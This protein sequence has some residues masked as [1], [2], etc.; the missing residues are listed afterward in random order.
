M[1]F[2]FLIVFLVFVFWKIKDSS[3]ESFYLTG[4]DSFIEVRARACD[5][6][7]V[8]PQI[9]GL[10]EELDRKWNRFSPESEIFLLNNSQQRVKLSPDTIV[11]LQKALF[12]KQKTGG[13]FNP[14]VASLVDVWDFSN[15]KPSVPDRK[16]L[17][18]LVLDIQNTGLLVNPETNEAQLLGSAGID[19]G[20]IGKG[21]LVD[22]ISLFFREMGVPVFLI[23]AGGTVLVRGKEFNIGIKDPRSEGIIGS[24][25]LKEGAVATSGDYFRFFVSDGERYF[26]ILNPF[27]GFPCRDFQSVTVVSAEGVLSDVLATALMAG[28]KA[29]LSLIMQNFPEIGIC[30][31]DAEGKVLIT[32]NML[33]KFKFKTAKKISYHLLEEDSC[34]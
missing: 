3:L 6:D 27:T 7:R 16:V 32:S 24:I 11:V 4:F 30:I 8:K 12:L 9:E 22:K 13:Y 10:V 25:T 31:V 20:G 5:L 17:Q 2:L 1:G 28:G 33:S 23:N 29:A 21:Y 19:L 14:F 26:H 18:K 15:S 34:L